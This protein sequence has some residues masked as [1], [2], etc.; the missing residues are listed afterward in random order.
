MWDKHELKLEELRA[1]TKSV[2]E[3]AFRVGLDVSKAK[4]ARKNAKVEV[5]N[6]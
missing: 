4:E 5:K 2:E 6:F 3:Q 1:S